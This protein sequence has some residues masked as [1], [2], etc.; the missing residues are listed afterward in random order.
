MDVWVKSNYKPTGQNPPSP[1]TLMMELPLGETP[2]AELPIKEELAEYR[3]RD[4]RQAKIYKARLSHIM[5]LVYMIF[6]YICPKI[7]KPSLMCTA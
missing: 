2:L 7:S 4:L 5:Y 1:W 3:H 6:A